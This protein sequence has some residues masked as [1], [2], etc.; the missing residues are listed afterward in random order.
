MLNIYT[1]SGLDLATNLGGTSIS[2]STISAGWNKVTF[3]TPINTGSSGFAVVID[4]PEDGVNYF[5][6]SANAA[7]GSS[8]WNSSKWYPADGGFQGS[9]VG[10]IA[11][12]IYE[13]VD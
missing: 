2:G 8:E 3:S 9:E 11:L 10:D 1:K 4:G 12:R 13:W 6:L 5:R 7:D